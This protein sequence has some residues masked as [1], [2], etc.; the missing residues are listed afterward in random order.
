MVTCTCSTLI[1]P[2]STSKI[3]NSWRWRCRWRRCRGGSTGGETGEFSPPPFFL[4]ALLSN[5]FSYP[6]NIWNN[7]R[8]LLISLIEAG[9]VHKRW[10]VLPINLFILSPQTHYS[11]CNPKTP[12]FHALATLRCRHPGQVST[13]YSAI[14]TACDF[15]FYYCCL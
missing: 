11:A 6:S 8:F 7:I 2:C 5:F 12:C 1:F 14:P 15:D 3:L 10:L 4:S 9:N 13:L